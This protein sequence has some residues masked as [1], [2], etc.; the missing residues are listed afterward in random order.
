MD[1][2][3]LK[4]LKAS[5]RKWEKNAKAET[6]DEFKTGPSECPLCLEFNSIFRGSSFAHCIGCPVF[7]ATGMTSC[8]GTPYGEAEEAA[9]EW[10]DDILGAPAA[11]RAAAR[12]E[13]DFLKGLL[14]GSA[15]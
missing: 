15:S 14:P 5:I 7:N 10:G 3:T 8:M 9:E 1:A 6:L 11:A 4:A 2:K 12:A 13:V